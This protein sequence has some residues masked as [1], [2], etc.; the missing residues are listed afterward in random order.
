MEAGWNFLG[1]IAHVAM[2]CPFVLG[3]A[4]VASVDDSVYGIKQAWS[5]MCGPEAVPKCPVPP[6]DSKVKYCFGGVFEDRSGTTRSFGAGQGVWL[7]VT[8]T[9]YIPQVL[10]VD[11]GFNQYQQ[12]NLGPFGTATL[13]FSVFGEEPIGYKFSY[14]KSNPSAI[15]YSVESNLCPR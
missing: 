6:K 15:T 12:Q 5:L 1:T 10:S 3:M 4:T 11:D 7:N 8:N 9:S 13:Y 14:N 2:A